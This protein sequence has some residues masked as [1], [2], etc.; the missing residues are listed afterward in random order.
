MRQNRQGRQWYT[1]LL[2]GLLTWLAQGPCNLSADEAIIPSTISEPPALSLTPLFEK[3]TGSLYDL[4]GAITAKGRAVVTFKSEQT[5][6]TLWMKGTMVPFPTS[7]R[8]ILYGTTSEDG[9]RW[10]SPVPVPCDLPGNIM[11]HTLVSGP[12]SK[13]YLVY[14]SCGDGRRGPGV[15]WSTTVDG[16]EWTEPQK[17]SFG[18]VSGK[19]D[20]LLKTLAGIRDP[21]IYS[22]G[23]VFTRDGSGWFF[24]SEVCR[25]TVYVAT[26]PSGAF[27]EF[28]GLKNCVEVPWSE[29]NFCDIDSQTRETPRLLALPLYVHD[30]LPAAVDIN[31]DEKGEKWQA[32]RVPFRER[33]DAPFKDVFGGWVSRIWYPRVMVGS[34]KISLVFQVYILGKGM[35]GACMTH[36]GERWSLPRLFALEEFPSGDT[37]WMVFKNKQVRG[38]NVNSSKT[39]KG[40]RDQIRVTNAL[41]WPLPDMSVF[42]RP[43]QGEAEAVECKSI[44]VLV[45][46]EGAECVLPI[47]DHTPIPCVAKV[48]PV[49][50]GP[51]VRWYLNGRD[52]ANG[53][54]AAIDVEEYGTYQLDAVAGDKVSTVHF[55]V[56]PLSDKEFGI[57]SGYS[58]PGITEY[59]EYK[60]DDS[61]IDLQKK[62]E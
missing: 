43:S 36:N 54:A 6:S 20:S 17:A 23:L 14:S 56:R 26:C 41:P 45:P 52:I 28:T 12:D 57:V 50:V 29:P 40:Y 37:L 39:G 59:Q 30:D 18:G 38:I 47:L 51:E 31:L 55:L 7:R 3:A 15:Y 22:V 16:K 10:D 61:I 60:Q 13:L 33:K 53:A 32:T 24:G 42:E 2:L 58:L 1:V 48:E 34:S 4:R 9:E 8:I 27:G 21:Q 62:K 49:E 5:L 19:S 44:Q 11:G 25:H 35:G 46:K